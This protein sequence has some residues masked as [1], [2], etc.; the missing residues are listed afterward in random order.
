MK[1]DFIAGACRVCPHS[2]MV[3]GEPPNFRAALCLFH[4]DNAQATPGK[5][6]SEVRATIHV[7]PLDELEACPDLPRA[8]RFGG[9]V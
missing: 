1:K 3:G 8:A 6:L 5:T 7:D 4:V 2:R 9:A